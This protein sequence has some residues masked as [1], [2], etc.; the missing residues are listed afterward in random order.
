MILTNLEDGRKYDVFFKRSGGNE[1][2]T[3]PACA[4]DRKKKQAK[5][6]SFD[7]EKNVGKCH[8]CGGR[9]V[10]AKKYD[11]MPQPKKEYVKPR[12]TNA[13]ALSEKVVEWFKNRGIGQQTLIDFKVTNG[14]DFMP[15][16]GKE[17]R[18]I[19]FN[20]FR[21]GELVNVKYRDGRKN[22]KL[23]KDAELIFYNLDAIKGHKEITLVEGECFLPN[24]EI[25]TEV[26]W[27]RLRHYKNNRSLK[28]AQF[29]PD[30]QSISYV[31]PLAFIEK[32][33]SGDMIEMKNSQRFYS[34]TTENHELVWIKPNGEYVK[35]KHNEAC[36]DYNIPRVALHNGNGIPLTDNEIRL[37]IAVSADFTLREKGDVYGALK[38]DR[39]VVRIREILDA[40][41]IEYS[42]KRDSRNYQS[43]FI[44]RG[45]APK[46]LFKLFPQNWIYQSTQEQKRLIISEILHWDGN[47]VPNRNQIE[48]SS[49][50][51]ENAKFI[52]T[53][54]HLCGYCSTIIPRKNQ[55]G[56]WYKVSI[57]FDKKTTS[58]QSLRKNKQA[59]KYNGLVNCVQVPSGMILVRQNDCISVS[60]NCD[61]MSFHEV[62]LTNVISV[63]NGATKGSAKLEYLDNCYE[64]FE[65][66]DKVYLATDDDEAGR[67]LRDELARRIGKE[68][69]YIVTFNGCKDANELLVKDR[70]ALLEV[71]KNAKPYP[72]EGIYTPKDY[73][74][75]LRDLKKNGLKAGDGISITQFNEYLTFVT[76]Y[77]TL[78]TGIPNHGKGEVLDQIMVDL[79]HL[80]EW[81]FG[82]FS[83]ENYPI[84][85]HIS[86]LASKVFDKSFN[87]LS[88][89]ELEKFVETYDETFYMIMPDDDLSL[90]SVLD[91]ARM[92]V[93]RKGIKGLVIDPWN[94]LDHQY[95]GN[96]GQYISRC[97]DKID[98]FSR[99][100][101]VHTFIV[102]HPTKMKKKQGTDIYEVPS[103]YDVS[104]SAHWFNKCANAICVYRNF[105]DDGSSD[106][107]IHVQKVKFKHWGRQGSIRTSYDVESGRYYVVGYRNRGSYL[108]VEEEK[109]TA[110]QANIAFEINP[111]VN[112]KDDFQYKTDEAP[113]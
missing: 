33:Y 63:P 32:P 87:Q 78:V 10:A 64:M 53:I 69:C 37:A 60:G 5:S 47:S 56:S 84:E 28:V 13:T 26:G 3:C 97:L 98:N 112:D 58:N 101:G 2:A 94:K 104:G 44:K 24:A 93:K 88:D 12:F 55:Y 52:Q 83:P 54:S 18:T 109:K 90:D 100:Y 16:T 105:Y 17:E 62:G 92:L 85:L 79:A 76:G 72:I 77:M 96:E 74:S 113:F 81:S 43:I 91:H 111:T 82:I 22:F 95:D 48:Y 35:R 108:T 38:K 34:I 73:L 40:L 41:G 110:I 20:Y 39:K 27:M 21:D 19:R 102:A 42:C 89:K 50:E 23:H 51:Y 70:L 107:D 65:N 9:F 57:L 1:A 80:H 99:V 68:K 61:A 45:N 31:H 59:V 29:N 67:A 14:V 8:H 6:L 4:Y 15:Q 25:L 75:N 71:V 106:T 46:Y 30:N 36:I 49:K 66:V 86:K 7:H 11:N 103:P